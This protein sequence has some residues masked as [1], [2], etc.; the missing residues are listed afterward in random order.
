MN[1]KIYLPTYSQGNCAYIR[2]GNTIR[3]YDSVPT[4]NATINYK[5]YFPNSHYLFNS[6]ST[7][8]SA[9]TTLPTCLNSS[10][11][12][13]EVYYRHDFADILLIFILMSFISFWVPWKIF[14]RLFRRFN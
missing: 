1:E 2:D 14:I 8:F 5:D 4:N 3:V 7:T 12:T 6:G 13:T 11:I 10:S 9:Y